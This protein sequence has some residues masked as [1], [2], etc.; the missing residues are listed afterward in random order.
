M[1]SSGGGGCLGMLA[2]M[3]IVACCIYAMIQL[4]VRGDEVTTEVTITNVVDADAAAE[5]GY[6]NLEL[7]STIT[8]KI[9]EGQL[10]AL[11]SGKEE[12]GCLDDQGIA[13]ANIV[14]DEQSECDLPIE[15]ALIPP[16]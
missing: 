4:V 13:L 15:A 2:F 3:A 5:L 11:R 9:W 10:E 14:T 8:I 12:V 7:G 1:N 6:E 16:R